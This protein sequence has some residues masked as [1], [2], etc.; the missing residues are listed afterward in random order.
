[1]I[2]RRSPDPTPPRPPFWIASI[3]LHAALVG[4]MVVWGA[5]SGAELP[6]VRPAEISAEVDYTEDEEAPAEELEEP[7][8]PEWVPENPFSEPTR[9]P[10]DWE[11]EEA[12]P[13]DYLLPR[14]AIP[15]LEWTREAVIRPLPGH[16]EPTEEPAPAEQPAPKRPQ[17][18]PP[19]TSPKREPP[20]PK[21]PRKAGKTSTARPDANRSPAPKYPRSARRRGLEGRVV[22]LVEINQRG[23]PTRVTVSKSSGHAA[24]DGAAVEALWKWRFIPAY[25]DGKPVDS[26][27]HQSFRFAL[28]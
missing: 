23:E 27:R 11:L 7:N 26:V 13:A 12:P 14:V 6:T 8:V 4:G 5:G 24:L 19:T 2:T 17:P 10:D 25:D 21:P 18:Q 3:A 22:L 9:S 1:M 28:K 20:A 15:P 16:E